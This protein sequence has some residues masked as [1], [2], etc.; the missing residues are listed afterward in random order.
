MGID[1]CEFQI[2]K[3]GGLK[4]TESAHMK[5]V[6]AVFRLLINPLDNL[7][8]NRL[9]L[10]IDKVGPKTAQKITATLGSADDPFSALA[11]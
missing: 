7:S 3:R 9:L 10:S 4:L 6:L 8:W 11:S 1:F 5:D 2:V